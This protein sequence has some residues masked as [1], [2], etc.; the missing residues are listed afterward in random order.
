MRTPKTL[1]GLVALALTTGCG[2]FGGD[3]GKRADKIQPGAGGTAGLGGTGGASGGSSATG[4]TA[5]NA[6]ASGTC[7]GLPG[8]AMVEIA[9]PKG[10]K[11]CIDRTEVTQAQYQAFLAQPKTTPGAEHDDCKYNKTYDPV[12]QPSSLEYAICI[13]GQSWTPQDTPNRP[14]VCIDWCDAFAYCS[15]AGKRLCGKVGGGTGSILAKVDDPADPAFD[16]D[17]SQ[18]YNAC[19][20]GG[21]TLFPYGD[22]YD[23]YACEGADVS[24]AADGGLLPKKDVGARAGCRGSTAPFSDIRDLSGSIV[25]L[26]DE[27]LWWQD[28]SPAGGSWKCAGRGGGISP[29]DQ[30]SCR[31]YSPMQRG[32]YNMGTGFR[33]C[34]DLP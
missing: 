4:G 9:T 3:D 11:Y 23:A 21:K 17:Q 29:E 10:V 31:W 27:C 5:A 19:S 7:L 16:A 6:G 32:D 20:Q 14:V 8:P 2:L 13:V 15:W 24:F 26:T 34:K 30:L 22:Q 33:C 25:E 12:Q 18:W 28:S 1:T